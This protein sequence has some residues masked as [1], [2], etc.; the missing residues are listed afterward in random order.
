MKCMGETLELTL[1]HR[2]KIAEQVFDRDHISHF[3][4]SAAL[5]GKRFVRIQQDMEID[6]SKTEAAERLVLE[7]REAGYRTQW[8]ET[9]C[10]CK[11][12][13]PRSSY[14]YLEL[15]IDW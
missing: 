2:E 14:S 5:S 9:I 10:P 8:L 3:M 1:K 13:R 11:P 7:L 15:E 12:V 4:T 6:L